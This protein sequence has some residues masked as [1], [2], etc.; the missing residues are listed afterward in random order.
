MKS[1]GAGKNL[2]QQQQQQQQNISV[3]VPCTVYHVTMFPV[4]L[5]LLASFN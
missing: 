2:Q 1:R 3:V 5:W 4:L